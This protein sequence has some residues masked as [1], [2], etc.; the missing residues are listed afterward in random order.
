MKSCWALVLAA[1]LPPPSPSRGPWC[2][3]FPT[4][5][6]SHVPFLLLGPAW[7]SRGPHGTYLKHL[8]TYWPSGASVSPWQRSDGNCVPDSALPQGCGHREAQ[9]PQPLAVPAVEPDHKYFRGVVSSRGPL[10]RSSLETLLVSVYSLFVP[11]S[12]DGFQAAF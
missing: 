9:H 4:S 6:F 5:Q 10:L 11:Y 12:A 8:C 3:C 7:P 1:R 2:S